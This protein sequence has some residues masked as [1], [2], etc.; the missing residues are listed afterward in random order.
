MPAKKHI[1]T[2]VVGA[3]GAAAINFTSIPQNGSD[4]VIEL[5]ARQTES[6]QVFQ[7]ISFN[8]STS[9]YV[10]RSLRGWSGGVSTGAVGAN[11]LDY[12][13]SY[14]TSTANAFSSTGIYIS[15][16]ALASPK[17]VSVNSG[18]ENNST[19]GAAS[20]IVA[21]EWADNAAITSISLAVSGGT[22]KYA[23]GS[24]ASLYMFTKG[25]GGASVA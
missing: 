5:S 24:T 4:L 14:A 25:S 1:A 7:T 21:M 15:G 3:G 9:A 13:L 19:S 16:Y 17:A 11:W 12:T 6:V 18:T 2:V 8:G 22:N 23:E 20:S 10:A